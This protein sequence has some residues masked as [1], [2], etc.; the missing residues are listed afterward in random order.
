MDKK[1]LL[2]NLQKNW[3]KYWKVDLFNDG[4]IRQRCKKCGKYFWAKERQD[5]CNDSS[6]VGYRFIDENYSNLKAIDYI[7]TWEK[8][9][10]FFIKKGHK[11]LK[12]YPIVCRWFPGLYFTIASIVAFQR[13]TNGK[14]VF[15]FPANP[16]IIP[17]FC[18]RF[19]DIEKVGFSGRHATAFVMV[20]QHSLYNGKKG[21]WKDEAI[22]LDYELLTKVFK[23]R[24]DAITFIEDVWLGE[25]AF[26][27]SLEYF[28]YGLELGNCVFTEFL[29]NI[30][31]YQ[32]M[33]EKVIDM[34]AGLERFSWI[35]NKTLTQYDSVY[36]KQLK[37]LSNYYDYDE[38]LVKKFIKNISLVDFD[39]F[40]IHETIDKILDKI[41]I[42]REIYNKKILPRISAYII[43]DHLRTL[44]L[45]L[46]DYAIPSNV[47]GGYNL[48]TI[49]RRILNY[50]SNLD[51]FDIFKLVK[52]EIST[53]KKFKKIPKDIITFFAEIFER[54]KNKF[55][56]NKEKAEAIT[57]KIILEIKE[58]NQKIIDA[59]KLLLLYQSY[60]IYPESIEKIADKEGL[61]LEIEKFR[62]IL[63]K[64]KKRS[65]EIKEKWQ[66][67]ID[68]LIEKNEITSTNLLYY[69]NPLLLETNSRVIKQF[70]YDGKFCLITES[71]IFYPE[72]GGQV[73]DSG[74]INDAK[75]LDVKK[76]KGIVVH[77]L[78]RPIKTNDVYLKVDG[79]R[80]M[81]IRQHHTSLHILNYAA[82]KIL[83]NHIWQAGSYVDDNYAT[84]DVSHY[85]KP[86]LEEIEEIEKLV[87]DIIKK[88]IDIKFE[89]LKR[90]KAEKKYGFRIYQGGAIPSENLRIVNIGD[91]EI[92]ACGGLHLTNTS[93]AE[94]FKIINV[95]KISDG[96]IRFKIVAGKKA[97]SI[98]D[99]KE[100][101]DELVK[102]LNVTREEVIDAVETVFNRWKKLRKALRKSKKPF[103]LEFWQEFIKKYKFKKIPLEDRKIVEKLLNFLNIQKNYLIVNV[104]K[105]VEQHDEIIKELKKLNEN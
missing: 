99:E 52:Y 75:V 94:I 73:A 105:F 11:A 4:W 68:N 37:F 48:R 18:L 91:F 57:K 70:S 47:G 8:I 88:N 72:G 59:E 14:T 92:E 69:D 101:V 51:D 96:V 100:I 33:K 3:E 22:N 89:W 43:C 83:G 103:E 67:E 86:N 12:S 42:N 64:L 40:L 76:Y 80:R 71:T 60:G 79:E 20:G 97:K 90:E 28:V 19:N 65:K 34:G 25:G 7:E 85:K 29:G 74:F 9:K 41:K 54:E 17:Q 53:I 55:E 56:E 104:K 39:K 81:Q 82:R 66:E 15:N 24:P 78:D 38:D 77:F 21:Y 13:K 95:E 87:N 32:L 31:N 2:E 84:L 58:K 98:E 6:C 50:K 35:I 23:I 16:L 36:K 46:S 44:V 10:N 45:A 1:I 5:Y 63:E 61:I 62:E 102:I 93:Q 30:D 26:G 27:Y 49:L